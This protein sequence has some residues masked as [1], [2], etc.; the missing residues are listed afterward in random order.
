MCAPQN[1]KLRV[2]H[3]QRAHTSP[4]YTY[5]QSLQLLF[6]TVCHARMRMPSQ[7]LAAKGLLHARR[8]VVNLHCSKTP[9]SKHPARGGTPISPRAISPSVSETGVLVRYMYDGGTLSQGRLCQ[10]TPE[11]QDAATG[12]EVLRVLREDG[13]DFT[14]FYACVYETAASTGGWLPL[15]KRSSANLDA[16]EDE[17]GESDLLLPLAEW[18]TNAGEV[19][20]RVDVKLFARDSAG[21]DANAAEQALTPCGDIP[22]QGYFGIGVVNSKNQANVGTL[23]RSSFQLGAKFIFTIGTRY[24]HSP[25]DTVRAVT[26]MPMFELDSWNDFVEF[27]PKGARWVAVEMGGTPVIST[28]MCRTHEA[29]AAHRPPCLLAPAFAA[30]VLQFSL[31]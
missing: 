2:G 5:M 25:T 11:R 16:P 27:A 31:R 23:W 9:L 24:R 13:V 1:H 29:I 18:D 12:R 3:R 19:S 4:V 17:Q 21:I 7:Q 22:I 15:L 6:I 10:L 26:R 20:R 8:G 28:A 14:R 30:R